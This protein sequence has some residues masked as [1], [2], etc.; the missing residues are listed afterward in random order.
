[1]RISRSEGTLAFEITTGEAAGGGVFVAVV[2]GEREEVLTG[3]HG[4]R[5]T[6]GDEDVGLADVDVDGA[7][8]ELGV[9]AGGEREPEAGHG[10]A[11]FLFH[12]RFSDKVSRIRRLR[13][14]TQD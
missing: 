2:A 13:S 7:A 8:R 3:T 14:A 11:M 5:S 4:G 6:G 12:F 9:G 1:M 10:D